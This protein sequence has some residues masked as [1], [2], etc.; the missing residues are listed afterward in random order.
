MPRRFITA[1]DVDELADRGATELPVDDGTTVTDVARERARER[2]IAI[3]PGAAPPS[4]GAQL[5]PVPTGD[6]GR[7]RAEVRAAVIAQLGTEPPQLERV[8]DQ[9]LDGGGRTG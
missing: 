7:V 2:G 1:R 9:V 4:A 3:V 5:P 8:I 6:R